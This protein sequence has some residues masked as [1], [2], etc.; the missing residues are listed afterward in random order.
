MNSQTPS[1][2]DHNTISTSITKAKDPVCGMMID[3]VTAKGGKSHFNDHDYYFCNPKCKIKFDAN[4]EQYLKPS[5]LPVSSESAA[6]IYTCPMHPEIKQKGPGTCPICGMALEPLEM[7]LNEGPNL[8]LLDMTK[9]FKVSLVFAVP[10][11]LLAM[12]EMIPGLNLHLVFKNVSYNWV[13]LILCLPVVI[14]SGLPV[15]ERGLQSIKNKNLNMFTLIA[16]GTGIAFLYSVFAT[17]F[18]S[19]FPAELK[20]LHTGE[21][22]VYFEAAAAI[23][24]LVLL[25][26]VLELRARSRTS[27]AIKALLGLAPKKALRVVN[28]QEEEI[29]LADVQVG[30]LLRVKPGEKIPVD[31]VV[32]SGKSS[33]DESM[34]SG[35]PIPVEKEAG[36][37]V[38]GGTINGTG[39]FIMQAQKVGADTLLAQ[40]VKMVSEAQRSKAPIQKLADLV[41]GYFVPVVIVI[42]VITFLVWFF[43]GPDPKLTYALVNAIAVLIIAC[44]CALG[45]A[46]PMSIMVGAGKGAQNGILI[47]N[48]EALEILSK[49]NTLVVDK[50]GTLTE[51][52]PSVVKVISDSITESE[53]LKIAASL[54]SVS[55]H[56]LAVAI[57]KGAKLKGIESLFKVENFLSLTG[58][59]IQGSIEGKSYFIGNSKWMQE[60]QVQFA[61][62]EK[63]VEAARSQGQTVMFLAEGQNLVAL[64]AVVD[65]IKATAQKAIR[66]LQNKNIEIIML[67][68]D[69]QVTAQAIAGQLGIKKFIADV[70]PQQKKE[71][72]ERLQKEGR[73]VAMAGDGVNDAPALAQAHVGIAMGHGT[74]VAIESAGITLIKGDL[75]GIVK[76]RNLSLQTMK[77]IKQNLFFAFIYNL[78]GVPIAAGVLFPFLGIL[79]SPMFA[80]A[81]MAL[82]SVSVIVNALRLGQKSLDD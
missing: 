26:Q 32:T 78:V 50:T 11:L 44:P 56:P 30:D 52:K 49:V 70:L 10:L 66:D 71:T 16:L 13:Q 4:P 80:S 51:G 46:T 79:L 82:S 8:E 2:H 77:N 17:V 64:I 73:I 53:A 76:A 45:L 3:P 72:V 27:G 34:V 31:G 23:I 57:V 68:G 22:G 9:R 5:A 35:E 43:L 12:S 67:T 59:G 55:E 39:S 28:G 25:G 74:D 47:K 18:P 62:F 40:I 33:V 58:Q 24:A 63:E 15:F 19:F 21:M 81:A 75:I 41:A 6:A 29:D 37:K 42:S 38:T 69:N 1:I 36:L 48:A 54:E 60:R 20:N 14:Y 61:K 65:Q 7:T